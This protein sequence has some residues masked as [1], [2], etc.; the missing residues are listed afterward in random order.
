MRIPYGAFLGM[1][2][3]TLLPARGIA[4]GD[5]ADELFPG[6][7]WRLELAA[8]DGIP[9]T[10]F[11]RNKDF[12]VSLVVDRE[13]PF[14][15]R[16]GWYDHATFSVRLRPLTY[17]RQQEKGQDLFAFGGGIG[18]RLFQHA[19]TYSGFFVEFAEELLLQDAKFRGNSTKFNF[20]SQFGLGYQSPGGWFLTL[21]AQHAS[22]ARFGKR[23]SGIN[24]VGMLGGFRF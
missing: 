21:R 13:Q 2:L 19:D 12:T 3:L 24:T 22:N 8:L 4:S 18:L 1:A 7:W 20:L 16:G 14:L 5:V 17:Y 23:N 6:P 9:S 11:D 10:H 15:W